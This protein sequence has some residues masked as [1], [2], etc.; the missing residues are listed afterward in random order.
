MYNGDRTNVTDF[1]TSKGE[2]IICCSKKIL[3]IVT[4]YLQLMSHLLT[5]FFKV[6]VDVLAHNVL[7]DRLVLAVHDVHVQFALAA[8]E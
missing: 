8:A 6:S 2:V 3:K 4:S 1:E 5:Q 7:G